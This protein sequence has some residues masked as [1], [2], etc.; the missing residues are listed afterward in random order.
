MI[1]LCSALTL[2]TSHAAMREAQSCILSC[3][4]RI[5][6]TDVS[7]STNKNYHKLMFPFLKERLVIPCRLNGKIEILDLQLE[8]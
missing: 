3:W 4:E 1:T 7:G 8:K 2:L 5:V 6:S